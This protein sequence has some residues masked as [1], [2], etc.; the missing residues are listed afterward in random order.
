MRTLRLFLPVLILLIAGDGLAQSTAN[1]SGNVT[2]DEGNAVADDAGDHVGRPARRERHD[3][4][5][6]AGREG[7]GARSGGGGCKKRERAQEQL[8]HFVLSA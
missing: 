8:N 5:D 2:S 6:L 4:G 3:D 1:L 7:L